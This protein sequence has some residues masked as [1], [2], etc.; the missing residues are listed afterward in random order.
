VPL[1]EGINV[2]LADRRC[3]Q[4][5][6]GILEP[7]NY[8][9]RKGIE[10]VRVDMGFVTLEE[11]PVSQLVQC[12]TSRAKGIGGHE[13]PMEEFGRNELVG[14]YPSKD[15]GF[16]VIQEEVGHFRIIRKKK[17]FH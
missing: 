11:I 14:M 1:L 8:C 15:F 5:C 9:S 3:R 16:I 2:S 6:P 10:G 12:F 17:K 13:L 7:V 4:D